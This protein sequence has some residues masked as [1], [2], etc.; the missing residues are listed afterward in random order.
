MQQMVDYPQRPDLVL[1]IVLYVSLCYLIACQSY[2]E[3]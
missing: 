3:L 1:N 2:V